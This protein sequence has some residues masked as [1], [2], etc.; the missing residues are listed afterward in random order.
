[1]SQAL[2][3]VIKENDVELNAETTNRMFMSWEQNT[4]KNKNTKLGNKPVKI[5]ARLNYLGT[6]LK[7]QNCVHE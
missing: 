4:G 1:M 7:H 3:L 6:T 5:V 2:F